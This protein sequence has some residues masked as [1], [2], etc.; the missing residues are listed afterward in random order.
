MSKCLFCDEC[1]IS[2]RQA[3][4]SEYSLPTASETLK[5]GIMIGAG[6]SMS[7][8][9]LNVTLEPANDYTLPTAGVSAKGCVIVG[10]GLSMTGDTLNCTISGGQSYSEATALTSGLMS[11]TDKAKLD[12]VADNANNY[13]LP[14]ASTTTKGGVVIGAG[15]SMSG[16]T[17]NCTTNNEAVINDVV[18]LIIEA[19]QVA[20]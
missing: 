2:S 18:A 14:T 13:T 16:D 4:S 19:L 12:N 9:T 6:L 20:T 1:P 15:L 7:G 17:L 5:G 8:D 11:A 3:S 10:T